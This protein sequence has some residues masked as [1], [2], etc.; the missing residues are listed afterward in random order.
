MRMVRENFLDEVV[1]ELNHPPTAP[2][3][4]PGKELGSFPRRENIHSNQ[5]GMLEG[6]KVEMILT[7]K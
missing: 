7:I 5:L 3:H 6:L 1:F 2:P 4:P